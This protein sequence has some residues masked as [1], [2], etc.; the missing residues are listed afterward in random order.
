M[1]KNPYEAMFIVKPNLSDADVQKIADSFKSVVEDNG[2]SV[3]EAGRWDKRRL[4]YPIDGHRDGTYVLMK[5][6]AP[7]DV[8]QE[9]SRLLRI[10]DD[11]I[12]HRVFRMDQ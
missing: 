5:F 12:R 10:H 11:V 3:S 4:S 2:G 9:L 6:D 7:A 8:P 1:S